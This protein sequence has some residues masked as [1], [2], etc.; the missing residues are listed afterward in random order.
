MET[1]TAISPGKANGSYTQA[2]IDAPLTT[3]YQTRDYHKFKP[4]HG[5]RI[6]NLA[7]VKRLTESFAL[8]HLV[9]P[10]I[11]NDKF[12]II[13][14]QHRFMVCKELEFPLYYIII[15]SYGLKEV[16][17]FNTNN[18][19]WTKRDYL[20]SYC[21]LGIRQYLEF[22]RFASIFPDFQITVCG[23]LLTDR[24][25]LNGL[26]KNMGDGRFGRKDFEAGNFQVHD[27]EK[28]VK[29]GK[30]I[31][32]FKIYYKGYARSCFVAALLSIFKNKNYSH[33]IMIKKLK[34]TGNIRL[35]DMPNTKSYLNLIEEIFNY[36]NRNKVSL[37]YDG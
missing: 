31:M 9:S 8:N 16:Q 37:R 36:K 27:F 3:V 28:A 19:V 21:Q 32:D 1:S 6:I 22:K 25:R 14:G 23:Q 20:E 7:H 13:D 30:R 12:E 11:V 5:N 17:V 10:I 4:L 26:E 34:T 33:D 18:S 24:K 15:K 29:N 35:Q 2:N